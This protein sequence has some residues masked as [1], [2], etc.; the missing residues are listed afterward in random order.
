MKQHETCAN[1]HR[2][3]HIC[4]HLTGPEEQEY[5]SDIVFILVVQSGLGKNLAKKKTQSVSEITVARLKC[6]FYELFTRS[7]KQLNEKFD[8]NNISSHHGPSF[9]STT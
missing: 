1:H 4:K 5:L 9:F 2:S 3:E 7:G 6:V 8:S